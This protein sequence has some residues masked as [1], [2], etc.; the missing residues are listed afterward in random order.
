MVMKGSLRARS[1]RG[2][3]WLSINCGEG[4]LIGDR[5]EDCSR[6]MIMSMSGSDFVN[7]V[8]MRLDWMR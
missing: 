4:G 5:G 2:R 1:W 3:V 8:T 7:V 6:L